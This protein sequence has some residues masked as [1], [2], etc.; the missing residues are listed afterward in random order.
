MSAAFEADLDPQTGAPRMRMSF[1][2]GWSISIVLLMRPMQSKCLTASV[3][4]CPTG[5]WGR[6]KTEMLHNEAFPDEVANLVAEV[7]ARENA[8]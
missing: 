1:N 3:A 2:N 4:A 7:A 5:C 6:G 8:A